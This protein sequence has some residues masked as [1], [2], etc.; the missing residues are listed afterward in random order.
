MLIDCLAAQLAPYFGVPLG[1]L[2]YAKL[3]IRGEMFLADDHTVVL[4]RF[5]HKPQKS[6]CE[7]DIEFHVFLYS[8]IS[9]LKRVVAQREMAPAVVYT[10]T[11][12]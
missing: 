11:L 4:D 7:S 6:G 3:G 5:T 10:R 8:L 2:K 1:T 12:V 9:S